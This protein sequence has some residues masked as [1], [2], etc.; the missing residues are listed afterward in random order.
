MLLKLSGEICLMSNSKS[1][2]QLE[3]YLSLTAVPFLL[4]MMAV[5]GF[6]QALTDL[7]IASEEIFRGEILPVLNFPHSE[8]SE[9]EET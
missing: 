4:S 6:T 7:G 3:I 9:P 5:R 2:L 8:V 1:P